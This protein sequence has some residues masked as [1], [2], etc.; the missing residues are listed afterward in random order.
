VRIDPT[1]VYAAGMNV[2]AIDQ[3]T[4]AT[5]ALVVGPDGAVL[6]AGIADVQPRF[7][8]GGA[9]EQDPAQLLDS[10]IAAG[11]AALAQAGVEVGAVGLGNQGETVLRWDLADGRPDGPAISWQDRR[12]ADI[13]RE[14]AAEAS[15]LTAIT[16]L[17]LDPYF[18]AP[19]IT[20][21][22]RQTGRGGVITTIDAWV[23][24]QL[25]GAFVTDAATASRTMLLDLDAGVWSPEACAVF[26]IDAQE[27]P[28]IVAGDARVGETGA[29]GP[30]LPVIGLAVDQQAA[31]LAEACVNRGD[32]KCTYGTGAFLLANA[33]D[34]A[35]RSAS[36][37]AACVAW[38]LGA[39][40]TYC[41]DGQVYT[42][43]AAISWLA[44]LGLLGDP[45]EIDAL[46]AQ[47]TDTGALF[48]PALAGLGAPFWAPDAKGGW[49]GL[50]LA[51]GPGDLVAAVIGGI[52]AQIAALAVAIG[53]DLGRPLRRLRVDG[54]L[55]R[56]RALL[57]AQAD[58]LQAPVERYPSADATALGVAALTRLGSGAAADLAVA[59][60]DW[61]PAEIFEPRIAADEA[62][63]R[64]DRFSAAA[65]A[66]AEL[67]AGSRRP[68]G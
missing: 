45:A 8:A 42:A 21:L 36:G 52:A 17:P 16:G 33:G 27:L 2:L 9:V 7:G 46:C 58:L 49:V 13:T 24:H 62:A 29:F 15:R 12:A 34:T 40:T 1:A 26:G 61:R 48:V 10:V 65:A 60:G 54:G 14:L 41:L 53:D 47:S 4:S 38:R 6:G 30:R 66:L 31:L 3:G 37:L 44:R 43:G 50:S 5:K 67:S 68:P 20:R 55:A 39:D 64:R 56:S 11:R 28:A 23:T 59:I 25:T 57:Q 63:E 19:K 35:P 32:A 51:T 18:A 22:R